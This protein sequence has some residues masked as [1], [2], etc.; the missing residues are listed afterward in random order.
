M[1]CCHR[2]GLLYQELIL[3]RLLCRR[4]A[5]IFSRD[6]LEIVLIVIYGQL[7]SKLDLPRT[8][9]RKDVSGDFS[10]TDGWTFTTFTRNKQPSKNRLKLLLPPPFVSHPKLDQNRQNCYLDCALRRIEKGHTVIT[11]NEQADSAARQAIQDGIRDDKVCPDDLKSYIKMKFYQQ[12]Q[13][14]WHYSGEIGI[15]LK[16]DDVLQ[17]IVEDPGIGDKEIISVRTLRPTRDGNQVATLVMRRDLV[18]RIM[19]KG[20]VK[21]ELVSCR[22][23]ERIHVQR[24]YRCLEFGPRCKDATHRADTTNCPHFKKIVSQKAEPLGLSKGLCTLIRHLKIQQANLNRSRAAHDTESSVDL[25]IVSEPNIK[26][27]SKSRWIT[28]HIIKVAAFFRK[29][30]VE[31]NNIQNE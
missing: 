4:E 28:V 29:R 22:T 5:P 10:V 26:L 17:D 14:E 7:F 21:I 24:C 16:E 11:E 12:W 19:R 8:D 30:N 31:V 1:P 15:T 9:T 2:Q 27:T 13:R 3:H 18:S 25:I 20:G 23:R 6:Q